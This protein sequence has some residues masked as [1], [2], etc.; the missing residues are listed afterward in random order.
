VFHVLVLVARVAA[1]TFWLWTPTARERRSK[2]F[3]CARRAIKSRSAGAL[4]GAG[5]RPAQCPRSGDAARFRRDPAHLGAMG[6]DAGER[7]S[8]GTLRSAPIGPVRTRSHRVV[9]RRAI[10][11]PHDRAHRS[12]GHIQGCVDRQFH[13]RPEPTLHLSAHICKCQEPVNAGIRCASVR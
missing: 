11:R 6:Q 4:A 13:R 2:R 10:L 12:A 3:I 8:R 9:H 5:F 1:L 7:V